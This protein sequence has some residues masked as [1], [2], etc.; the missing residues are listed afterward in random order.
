MFGCSLSLLLFK[1]ILEVL[2]TAIREEKEIEMKTGK[3]EVKTV[4]VCR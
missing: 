3:E 4:T 1:V 2:G